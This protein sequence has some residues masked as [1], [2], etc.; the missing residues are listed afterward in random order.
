MTNV[1]RE[2][3]T[4]AVER[5]AR[6]QVWLTLLTCRISSGSMPKSV[7]SQ[8]KGL[9]SHFGSWFEPEAREVIQLPLPALDA[10]V[11]EH[12]DFIHR[13]LTSAACLVAADMTR[14]EIRD[15]DRLVSDFA[16]SLNAYFG[17]APDDWYPTRIPRH[18]DLIR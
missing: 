7:N 11:R 4:N 14:A 5:I 17:T 15:I 13:L 2:L 3:R 16:S 1:D 9:L 12:I 8:L 10:D 6:T 18:K